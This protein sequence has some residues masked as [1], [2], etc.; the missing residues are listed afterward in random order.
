MAR[1]ATVIRAYRYKVHAGPIFAPT[2]PAPVRQGSYLGSTYTALLYRR[3]VGST[4][5]VP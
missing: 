4:V 3:I 1:K 5:S 2:M